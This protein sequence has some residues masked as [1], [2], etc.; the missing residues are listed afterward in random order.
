M[1]LNHV[2]LFSGEFEFRG[3]ISSSIVV[4]HTFTQRPIKRQTV[5][6]ISGFGVF[7]NERIGEQVLNVSKAYNYA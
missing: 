3:G 2:C 6:G 5:G 4:P 1:S 7:V